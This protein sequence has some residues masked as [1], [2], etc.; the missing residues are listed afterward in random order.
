M[1][2]GRVGSLLIVNQKK[3]EGFITQ[4]DILWALVKKPSA[5]L[6]KIMAIDISPKKII[7]IKQD[8]NLREAISKMNKTKFDRLPVVNG[9]ELIGIIT[10]KDILNFHPEVYPELEE[11]SRIRE[12]EE[13][14]KRLNELKESAV[15]T[16]GICEECGNRDELYR[17]HG[18][19]VCASCKDS[20]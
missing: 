11:V 10:A 14:L 12:E 2:R 8:A 6:T 7:T 13:K 1:A 9:S 15:V 16:D 3:L 18:M 19:L 20:I 17:I 5:D 4:R